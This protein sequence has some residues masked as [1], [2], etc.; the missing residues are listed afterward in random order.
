MAVPSASGVLPASFTSV[1]D[2]EKTQCASNTNDSSGKAEKPVVRTTEIQ[3]ALRSKPQRGRKRDNLSE[4]E[5]LELT[6]TRN[7]E[8]AKSTR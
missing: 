3:A 6:R 2:T 5:R 8:H 1:D 4:L 7:R